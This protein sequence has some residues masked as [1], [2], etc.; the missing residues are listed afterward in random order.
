MQKLKKVILQEHEQHPFQLVD[1]SSIGKLVFLL[2][3]VILLGFVMYF[4]YFIGG[5]F[6]FLLGFLF[7]YSMFFIFLIIKRIAELNNLFKNTT[8]KRIAGGLII[9]YI[10]VLFISITFFFIL[11]FVLIGLNYI[12]NYDFSLQSGGKVSLL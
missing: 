7:F 10:D 6:F 1:P 8:S 3:Y 9:K 2:T 11:Y 4:Q 5:E 12:I